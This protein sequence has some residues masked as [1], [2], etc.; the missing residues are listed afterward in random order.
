LHRPDGQ[1]LKAARYASR[2]EQTLLEAAAKAAAH[3][4]MTW[5]K[6]RSPAE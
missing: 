5:L 2:H 6:G 4:L 3:P 1:P